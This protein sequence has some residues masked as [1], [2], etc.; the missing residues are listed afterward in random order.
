MKYRHAAVSYMK[1]NQELYQYMVDEEIENYLK[2]VSV[3]G[4]AVDQ[5]TMTAVS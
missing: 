3:S 2:K 4:T 1:A 5:V